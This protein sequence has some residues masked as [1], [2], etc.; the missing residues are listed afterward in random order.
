MCKTRLLVCLILKQLC[1]WQRVQATF[2]HP[3]LWLPPLNALASWIPLSVVV[4]VLAIIFFIISGYEL[5][6]LSYAEKHLCVVHTLPCCS[7][8]QLF[9]FCVLPKPSPLFAVFFPPVVFPSPCCHF[10]S[11]TATTVLFLMAN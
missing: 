3:F 2:V 10:C 5:P 6:V 11:P 9:S 8:S 4:I 1:N 7:L